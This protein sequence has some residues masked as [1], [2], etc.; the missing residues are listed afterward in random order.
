MKKR[1]EVIYEK[2]LKEYGPQGWWPISSKYHPSDYS[3]PKD[4][5]E[6]FEIIIGALLTQNTQWTSVEKSLNNLKKLDALEP[7]S[8][9]KLDDEKLK[10]AIRPSGYFNHKS[11]RLKLLAEWFLKDEGIPTREDLL[12]LNGIGPETADSILLYA[13]KV[14]SFV[15]DTYTKR[16]LMGLELIDTSFGYNEIKKLFEGTLKP[17]YKIFQEF[18]ALLVEHAK[19][20]KNGKENFLLNI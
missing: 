11:E 17:D 20:L 14:P 16:I 4:K 9:L 19:E 12:K 10:N 1:L 13:Y 3:F 18:H 2:L 7:R 8:L 6:Q 15:V 5:N